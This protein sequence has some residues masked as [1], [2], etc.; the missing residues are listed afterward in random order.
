[1][2]P[3]NMHKSTHTL[4]TKCKIWIYEY[5]SSAPGTRQTVGQNVEDEVMDD[6]N[7]GVDDRNNANMYVGDDVDNVCNQHDVEN[8]DDDIDEYS[9]ADEDMEDVDDDFDKVAEEAKGL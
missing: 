3:L 6:D 9:Y 4:T 8:I 2:L 7:N 5:I 1:M